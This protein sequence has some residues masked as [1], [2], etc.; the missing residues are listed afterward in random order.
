M[1]SIVSKFWIHPSLLEVKWEAKIDPTIL[2]AQ[3]YLCKILE[4]DPQV[5]EVRVGYHSLAI[6]FKLPISNPK[7]LDFEKQLDALTFEKPELSCR[8]WR[9][10]VCYSKGKD[11]LLLAELKDI[12]THALIEL[13]SNSYYILHFYGFL[14]GFMYLGGLN[15]QLFAKRK[16]QPD[17]KIEAGSVGIG[18]AQTG[19]YTVD[20]P[21]GWHIVGQ[22]PIK[23]FDVRH[24]PPVKPQIGDTIRFY[25]IDECLFKEIETINQ[26]GDYVWQH[27]I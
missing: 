20:S 12:S 3:Q 17:P 7:R 15:E 27:E 25:P 23:L 6:V 4:K 11:L 13:H 18:G 26:K 24:Q 19:I 2:S 22:T 8:E 10:P 5:A 9:I 14:P 16:V 21:G 1:V